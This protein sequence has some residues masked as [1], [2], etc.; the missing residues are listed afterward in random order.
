MFFNHVYASNY[1]F[2]FFWKRFNYLT[3]SSNFVAFFISSEFVFS[4]HNCDI[5]ANFYTHI[6]PLLYNTS[7]ASE[8]ILMKFFSLNSLATGPNILVP[9]GFISSFKTTAALSSN[10]MYDPSFLLRPNLVLTITA[11]TI[12]PFLT[13][14]FGIAFLTLAVTTSPT[15][16]YFLLVP[17]RTLIIKS[18][19]APLLSATFTLVSCCNI[20]SLLKFQLLQ[21]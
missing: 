9:I 5:V 14:E 17:P 21:R 18:S 13:A 8:I 10:L 12:S 20:K 1:N 16:A 2:I 7:G 19:L 15:L 6:N 3:H 11:V 4:A